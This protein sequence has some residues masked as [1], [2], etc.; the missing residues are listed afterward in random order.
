MSPDVDGV[1]SSVLLSHYVRREYDA[2]AQ[3]VGTFNGRYLRLV[4]DHSLDV[5]RGS[6]FLDL[7]VRFSEVAHSIGQHFLGPLSVR[8]SAGAFN[9]NRFFAIEKMPDKY[10]FATAHLLLFGLLNTAKMTMPFTNTPDAKALLSHADSFFWVCNKYKANSQRWADRLYGAEPTP[11]FLRAMLDGTY[12]RE[13][14]ADH[15]RFVERL[16]P[17]VYP[18][19][20]QDDFSDAWKS[21]TGHQTCRSPNDIVH[22]RNVNALA[23]L[24]SELLGVDG[25]TTYDPAATRVVWEGTKLRAEAYPRL[26]E[27]L[28][29]YLQEHNIRSHAVTGARSIAMS[30][31]PDL[32]LEPTD[33]SFY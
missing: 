21:C 1:L 9:P 8:A 33:A 7:D 4:G 27:T 16:K 10:P 29:R 13:A 19:N 20:V 18:G 11:P 23:A 22:A 25:P 26:M 32:V 28:E 15:R 31:G 14:A 2:E 24:F 3:L 6:M 5:L 12:M 30:Q 17:H